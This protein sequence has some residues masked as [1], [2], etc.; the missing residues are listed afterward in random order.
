MPQV[1][2][3]FGCM[4]SCALTLCTGTRPVVVTVGLPTETGDCVE[5]IR[6][7]EFDL[8]IRI[9]PDCR[10]KVTGPTAEAA[11]ATL[12]PSGFVV[13]PNDNSENVRRLVDV[14]ITKIRIF[15]G[16]SFSEL[17]HIHIEEESF[18]VFSGIN[19]EYQ[20]YLNFC[21]PLKDENNTVVVSHFLDTWMVAYPKHNA[22][23]LIGFSGEEKR[24]KLLFDNNRDF[25]KARE[26]W[27]VELPLRVGR[28]KEE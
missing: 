18:N 21:E 3:V 17:N 4:C 19:P 26:I 1:C 10:V 12:F 24:I 27:N 15:G 25:N 11:V 6:V 16:F 28:A 7:C 5:R 9:L 8:E 2:C 20:S 23:F 14:I 13:R 22:G